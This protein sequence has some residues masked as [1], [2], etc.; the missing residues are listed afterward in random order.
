MHFVHRRRSPPVPG[1]DSEGPAIGVFFSPNKTLYSG[2]HR[3]QPNKIPQA[4]KSQKE[5]GALQIP[6]AKKTRR[7]RLRNQ[8]A[9]NSMPRTP[10]IIRTKSS[11]LGIRQTPRRP[12]GQR[13]SPAAAA[14]ASSS[15]EALDQAQ[16]S[17]AREVSGPRAW[18]A[19]QPSEQAVPRGRVRVSPR[20]ERGRGAGEAGEDGSEQAQEGRG[21]PTRRPKSSLSRPGS[22]ERMMM[23]CGVPPVSSLSLLLLLRCVCFGCAAALGLGEVKVFLI[24]WGGSSCSSLERERECGVGGGQAHF[25]LF[26][27]SFYCI[28]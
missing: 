19:R 26:H 28:A 1:G 13:R 18:P 22:R 23:L 3:N 17:P 15:W 14:A 8:D 9:A 27:L 6:Q 5:K 4:L 10:A 2:I 20:H 11:Y 7:N 16:V 21:R 24:V 12:A 25:F